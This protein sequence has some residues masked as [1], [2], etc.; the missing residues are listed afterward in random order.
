ME[1]LAD[2]AGLSGVDEEDPQSMAR[3]MNRMSREVGE[4]LGEGPEDDRDQALQDTTAN[5]HTDTE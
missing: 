2:P 3:W 4:D 1:A 5:H